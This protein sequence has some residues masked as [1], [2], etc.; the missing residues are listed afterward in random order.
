MMENRKCKNKKCS[1]P[2]P[3]GYK[4]KY[5]EN[6]RNYKVKRIK[7]TGKAVAGVA[8]LIGGTALTII[9]NGKFKPKE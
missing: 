2:L 1:R 5:C 8:I 7:D 4:Y 9:T 6:C 3:D